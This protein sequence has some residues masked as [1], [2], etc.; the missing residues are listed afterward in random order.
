MTVILEVA[1][2]PR[3]VERVE[4]DLLVAGFFCE[5]RPLKGAAGTADWRLCGLVSRILLEGECSGKEGEA[6]LVASKGRLRIG[7]VLLV[8]LGEAGRFCAESFGERTRDATQRALELGAKRLVLEPLGIRA[9]DFSPH[10][11]TLLEAVLAPLRAQQMALELDLL[12]PEAEMGRAGAAL[13]KA[14]T[15]SAPGEVALV[16]KRVRKP[17]KA[18]PS[19]L[20]QAL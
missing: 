13:R 16:A 9:E 20:Q 15:K 2:E 7:R 18:A 6:I 17:L 12:I 3:S 8:G 4:G 19:G 5:D 11:G 10:C 1:L 14:I